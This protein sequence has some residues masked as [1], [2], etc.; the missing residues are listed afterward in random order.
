MIATLLMTVN[1]SKNL[2]TIV[3]VAKKNEIV[4]RD[5]IIENFWL[6]PK[7]S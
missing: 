1:L 2:L 4:G 5:E 7:K 6:C 3:N